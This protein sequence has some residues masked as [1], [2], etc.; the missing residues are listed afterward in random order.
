MFNYSN[1]ANDCEVNNCL[2][3][4]IPISHAPGYRIKR[5][6]MEEIFHLSINCKRCLPFIIE[7]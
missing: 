1:E 2:G 3:S 7:R 4:L 5:K 6:R